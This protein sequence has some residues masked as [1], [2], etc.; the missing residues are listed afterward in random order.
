MSKLLS[1]AS[2]ICIIILV[3]GGVVVTFT[4]VAGIVVG[5]PDTVIFAGTTLLDPVCVIAGFS[6]VFAYLRTYTR[7]GK[8]EVESQD[9]R[10]NDV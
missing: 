1:T 9:V 10:A 2:R 5:D 7:A 6:G 3:L 4:Q 8:S